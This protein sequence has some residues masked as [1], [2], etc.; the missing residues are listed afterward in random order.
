MMAGNRSHPSPAPFSIPHLKHG[1][2]HSHILTVVLCFLSVSVSA[3]LSLFW[4]VSLHVVH[5]YNDMQGEIQYI[6]KRSLM[7]TALLPPLSPCPPSPVLPL[8]ATVLVSYLCPVYLYVSTSKHECIFFVLFPFSCLLLN[9][10]SYSFHTSFLHLIYQFKMPIPWFPLVKAKNL[11]PFTRLL[12]PVPDWWCSVGYVAL[13]LLINL[14]RTLFLFSFIFRLS[15]CPPALSDKDIQASTLSPSLSM[16]PALSAVSLP[17]GVTNIIMYILFHG[18]VRSSTFGLYIVFKVLKLRK[19]F[20][21]DHYLNWW[22]L[23]SARFLDDKFFFL[24]SHNHYSLFSYLFFWCL[25]TGQPLHWHVGHFV[26]NWW[27][28][29]LNCHPFISSVGFFFN[30]LFPH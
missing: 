14:F 10:K 12:F 4:L 29:H 26:Y 11:G 9:F 25:K 7:L 19:C 17:D 2:S 28:L 15:L 1:H 6:T 8:A 24:F 13:V 21:F 30:S 5:K 27:A 18:Q 23:M 20:H 3:S 16:P 22:G